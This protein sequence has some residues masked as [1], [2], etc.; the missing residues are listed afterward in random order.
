[1]MYSTPDTRHVCWN[2]G[3][4]TFLEREQ[5]VA[6]LNLPAGT[7]PVGDDK[8]ESLREAWVEHHVLPNGAYW[9]KALQ[10][11]VR[12]KEFILEER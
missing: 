9:P 5:I 11:N 4:I 7:C 6:I 3:G 8:W 12:S 10:R 1:M 2:R